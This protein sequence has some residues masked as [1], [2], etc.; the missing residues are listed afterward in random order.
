MLVKGIAGQ[1]IALIGEPPSD[2]TRLGR[3]VCC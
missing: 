3:E 2:A 1:V